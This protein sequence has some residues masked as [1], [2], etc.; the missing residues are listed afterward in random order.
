MY[1]NEDR[2]SNFNSIYMQ[3]KKNCILNYLKIIRKKK[4]DGKKHHKQKQK[5]GKKVKRK[6]LYHRER[7]EI[8]K[9][10]VGEPKSL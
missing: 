7:A 9:I 6:K 2:L 10:E 8:L 1:P 4:H 5:A 3:L